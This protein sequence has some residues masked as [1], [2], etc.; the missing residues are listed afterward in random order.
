MVSSEI[1]SIGGTWGSILDDVYLIVEILANLADDL[2]V[3]SLSVVSFMNHNDFHSSS[4]ILG[5]LLKMCFQFYMEGF[6]F[7]YDDYYY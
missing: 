7:Q 2:L 3:I 5:K 1:Q 6:L 4:V